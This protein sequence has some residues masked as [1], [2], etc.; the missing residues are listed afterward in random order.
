MTCI[1]GLR[2]EDGIVYLGADSISV[3]DY[4]KA[5]N[6]ES[7]V[8]PCENMIIGTCGSPRMRNILQHRLEIP[9]YTTGDPMKY[10]VG[11]FVDAVRQEFERAG[12]LQKENG[13]EA[14]DGKFLIGFEGELYLIS[15]EF[16]VIRYMEPY[17]AIG[18][19]ESHAMGSLHSTHQLGLE[20]IQCIRAALEAAAS[21][22]TDVSGPFFYISSSDREVRAL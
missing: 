1:V 15:K 19:G 7:K 5:L 12:H 13:K 20:P 4:D 9:P 18:S 3:V 16:C 2:A 22:N 11:P 8:F 6:G 21:H 17:H 10:L 14:V